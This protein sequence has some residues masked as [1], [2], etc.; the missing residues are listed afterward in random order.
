MSLSSTESLAVMSYR[1]Q[2]PARV[3]LVPRCY[4]YALG[5]ARSLLQLD[6]VRRPEFLQNLRVRAPLVGCRNMQ[7][8]GAH[9]T[10]QNPNMAVHS[11]EAAR[12][13]RV[14]NYNTITH[15]HISPS[16]YIR[17]HVKPYLSPYRS[18]TVHKAEAYQPTTTKAPKPHVA[19][20]QYQH[21]SKIV[22]DTFRC[23][24]HS[25]LRKKL[26]LFMH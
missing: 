10:L 1:L 5:G 6:Q 17:E 9:Y 13:H 18:N 3:G 15:V 8:E 4:A 22:Y 20:V 12:S 7:A 26:P 24:K 19:S 23:D 16:A 2:S 21:E 25:K 14:P 11:E